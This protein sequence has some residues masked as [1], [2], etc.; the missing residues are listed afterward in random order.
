MNPRIRKIVSINPFVITA[1]WSDDLVRA[2]D[3]ESLVAEYS[4]RR[5]SIYSKIL[6]PEIFKRA[7]TDG[8]TIYWE[9]L[10]RM[11]DY[12]GKSVPA[13]LDFDPDM[14]FERSVLV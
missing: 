5:E 14:L 2:V 1:L 12:N 9:G 6:Q 8:I 10:A 3:F 7:K 4:N 11:L 13:P